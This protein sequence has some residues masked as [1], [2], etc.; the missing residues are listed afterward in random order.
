M[1]KVPVPLKD[2]Q[3][4]KEHITKWAEQRGLEVTELTAQSLMADEHDS[5]EEGS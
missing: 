5:A 2:V 1:K 3:D 4:L